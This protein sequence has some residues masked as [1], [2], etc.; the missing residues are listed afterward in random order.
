ME[1]TNPS[2]KS[3]L[4]RAINYSSPAILPTIW[5]QDR[6][7]PLLELLR[8]A[9]L[10]GGHGAAGEG[11]AQRGGLPQDGAGPPRLLVGLPG[12]L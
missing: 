7:C 11:V 5:D 6:D 12:H 4:S 3:Q 9:L 8:L 2:H 1:L 10:Q